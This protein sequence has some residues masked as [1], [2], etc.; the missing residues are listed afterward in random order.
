MN[1]AIIAEAEKKKWKPEAIVSDAEVEA[2]VNSH[3][4]ADPKK[5]GYHEWCS[6]GYQII[7]LSGDPNLPNPLVPLQKA[8]EEESRRR[9][10]AHKQL[11][12]HIPELVKLYQAVPEGS[13]EVAMVIPVTIKVQYSTSANL[14][15]DVL[16]RGKEPSYPFELIDRE[17]LMKMPEVVTVVNC[18]LRKAY[19]DR[20]HE[21][22]EL[23]GLDET[24]IE[25]ATYFAIS[26]MKK[27]G[28][29]KG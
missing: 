3:H 24:D 23:L 9:Q 26:D 7:N 2:I 14:D 1:K 27:A 11:E 29:L 16:Q 5:P 13:I 20:C 6:D 10:E 25:N 15:L 28:Q 17:A 12:Q 8:R 21:L 4:C 19:R 22:A 18:P